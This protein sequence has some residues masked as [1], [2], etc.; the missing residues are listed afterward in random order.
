MAI[1]KK[2]IVGGIVGGIILVMLA[3]FV[4]YKLPMFNKYESLTSFDEV[5]GIRFE[6]SEKASGVYKQK[7]NTLQWKQEEPLFTFTF[8]DNKTAFFGRY[9]SGEL[10]Y[11]W[12][13][14]ISKVNNDG[15]VTLEKEKLI[16][17]KAYYDRLNKKT[18]N[19][20]VLE[21]REDISDLKSENEY[22]TTSNFPSDNREVSYKFYLD[23]D[24]LIRETPK[25]KKGIVKYVKYTNAELSEGK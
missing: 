23:D 20:Y 12:V 15:F 6:S 21:K 18:K 2:K 22:Y 8:L 3:L 7:L 4:V 19:N 14:K 25:D 1:K 16:V 9:K 24:N 17:S 13:S 10:D 5:K 11:G